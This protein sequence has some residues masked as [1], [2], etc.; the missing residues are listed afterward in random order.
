MAIDMKTDVVDGKETQPDCPEYDSF[1]AF[2][3]FCATLP[4]ADDWLINLTDEEMNDFIAEG[5]W[6]KYESLSR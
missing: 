3:A 4:P 1:E 6:R 2:K 5:H